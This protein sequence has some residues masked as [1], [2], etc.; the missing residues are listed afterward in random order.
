MEEDIKHLREMVQ[1]LQGELQEARTLLTAT[2]VP[3]A[4]KAAKLAAKAIWFDDNSDFGT[5]LWQV[6]EALD[7]DALPYLEDGQLP[8]WMVE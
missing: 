4:Q 6:V 7:P 8:P 5:A 2:P 1:Q 3:N